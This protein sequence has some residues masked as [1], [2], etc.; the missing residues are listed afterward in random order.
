MSAGIEVAVWPDG[1]WCPLEE[2]GDMADLLRS[3]SDDYYIVLV[4]AWDEDGS[5]AARYFR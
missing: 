2:K 1:T 5:P 3:K 4:E